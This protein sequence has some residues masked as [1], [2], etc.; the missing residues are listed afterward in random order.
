MKRNGISTTQLARICGVSQGTVDRALNGRKGISQKTK[1]KILTVAQE[2]GYR[3]NIH[4]RSI[5]GGKSMLIGVVVFDLK[6]QYF[7]DIL[8]AIEKE[9][10]AKGY[11]TIA[12]FTNK[13]ER[14]E[15][16][17]ID[18]LYHMSVDGI[19][20]CPINKGE[21]YENYLSSLN[22]PIVTIGN[23]LEKIPYVG[24]DNCLSMRETVEYVISNG[25]DKLIDVKPHLTENNT[26]AQTERLNTFCHMCEKNNVEFAVTELSQAEKEIDTNRKN[27]FICP[28][29]IYAIKLLSIAQRY[30][31]GII[32]YDNIRLIDELN[33]TL[34]SVS[35]DID[36]TARILSDYIIENKN[37]S[38]LV[39]HTLIKRGSI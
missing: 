6:N 29:D 28:T 15:I 3:P 39:K 17:C 27:A 8:T 13:D 16:A 4:A 19:V 14:T 26:F 5:A 22:M 21:E 1:E 25:Y 10:T 12:M 9:C 33:L 32:G 2:Y 7:S 18:N 24:I 20:L 35:Y 36:Q 37:V 34:D 23:K 30:N 31:A 38:V 11:S